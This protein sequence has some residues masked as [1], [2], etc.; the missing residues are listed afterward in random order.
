MCLDC[1]HNKADIV[2][3]LDASYSEGVDN[4]KK[5]LSFVINFTKAY[6]I[7]KLYICLKQYINIAAKPFLNYNKVLVMC[8]VSTNARAN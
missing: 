4:F 1:S 5:Q 7:G 8:S 2:F 3:L 6:D